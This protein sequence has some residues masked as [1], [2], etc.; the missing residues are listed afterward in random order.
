MNYS[1]TAYLSTKGEY[2]IF[3]NGDRN[4]SFLTGK[5]LKKYLRIKERDNGYIVVECLNNDNTQNEDYID[6]VPILRNLYFD[7]DEFLSPIKE[8]RIHV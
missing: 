3:S 1:N 5:R 8:V 7:P 2:T 4:I 6:L